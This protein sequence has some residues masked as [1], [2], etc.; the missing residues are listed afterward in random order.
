[1]MDATELLDPRLLIVT[2]KGGVGK[3]TSAAVLAV[4]GAR[5]GKRTCLVEVEGRQTMS[6]L[7]GTSPW[8]FEEREFRPG[9]F[10][11]SVDPE[12]S[13]AEYLEMFY[14]ARRLSK[15]VVGSTAVEFATTAAPGIKDVLL[16]GKVN[17]MERRRHPDGRP[18]YDLIV[19]DAPPTGRIVNFLR[20]PEATTEL[21]DVGPIRTQAKLLID[22][23]TDPERTSLQLV[24][25]LE[26]L[27]VQETVESV[28]A[29]RELGMAIG[30]LIVNRVLPE[31]F[32]EQARKAL[33]EDLE[34][35]ELRGLLSEAGLDLDLE[36]AAQLRRLGVGDL[37]RTDLQQRM[38]ED[39]AARVDV[40][41][42]ELRELY[43]EQF[44]GREVDQLAD[45]LL[46]A[47]GRTT[48]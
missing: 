7:F 43:G 46:A 17:E 3:S 4:A 37:G 13:L 30:P 39:L 14:G 2:G 5:M 35:G 12:A 26:E 10:G 22:M 44:T 40:P 33:E 19:M 8:G 32:D 48:A 38:R 25:I 20:A 47:I 28:A 24:T 42:I 36:G 6:R 23:M 27:P 11:L 29:L 31:R 18:V 15:L 34:P 45:E 1:M 41:S 9:L 21:V 16:V